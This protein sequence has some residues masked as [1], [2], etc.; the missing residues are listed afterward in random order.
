MQRFSFT[1][2]AL[3]LRKALLNGL[4][5]EDMLKYK[6]LHDEV[7][8]SIGRLTV[9]SDT[10]AQFALAFIRGVNITSERFLKKQGQ[11]KDRFPWK[12]AFEDLIKELS[13]CGS[14]SGMENIRN[15]Y[16]T[17]VL[18]SWFPDY[19]DDMVTGPR[20]QAY[21]GVFEYLLLHGGITRLFRNMEVLQRL[22]SSQVTFSYHVQSYIW[23][24]ITVRGKQ[25][26]LLNIALAALPPADTVR[27][28]QHLTAGQDIRELTGHPETTEFYRLTAPRSRN[29]RAGRGVFR[30]LDEVLYHIKNKY[31]PDLTPPRICWGNTYS[32]RLL[33][34]YRPTHDT[35]TMSPVFDLPRIPDEFIEFIVYHELLHKQLGT[36]HVNGR[37]YSHT[38]E[39]R[40]MESR[41]PQA[42]GIDRRISE[43]MAHPDLFFKNLG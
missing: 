43:M 8:R 2:Y 5:L 25:S 42:D 20:V 4:T 29:M 1:R 24:R 23:K 7:V 16:R 21:I 10:A 28:I 39:F 6:S 35:I 37:A 41:F 31:L 40:R 13:L 9:R 11:H 27:M 26:Y 19:P 14:I 22:N 18:P 33:G 36:V 32:V 15:Y 3:T 30:D 12:Q 17:S 34:A 38:P